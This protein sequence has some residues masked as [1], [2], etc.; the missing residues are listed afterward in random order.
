MPKRLP[1]DFYEIQSKQWKKSILIL[2][3]LVLFYFAAIGLITLAAL[4]SV[5]LFV[6]NIL[7]WS[8]A[9]FWKWL[10]AVLAVASIVAFLHF[11]EAR[12]TGAPYI[13]KRLD[14]RPP[15]PSDHYH[16]QFADTVEEMR[17]ASGLPRVK[18]YIIPQFAVNSMALIEPDGTPCVVV[19]EGLL[20]DCTRNELQAMAAHELA[21]ISRGDAF[22][23][24]LVCSLGNFLEKL[25]EAL[26]PDDAPAQERAESGRGGAPP[27]FIYL[28]LISTSIIVRLLSALLSRERET[29]ADAAA[30]EISRDP[31]A[32]ARLLYKAH[33]K[34][35]LIGDF[36]LTYSPLFIVAPQLTGESEGFFSRLFNSHPPLMKRI[37]LLAEQAGLEPA[38]VIQ[39]VWKDQ[40][41][42][43]EARTRLHSFAE[44]GPE[45][46]KTE[47]AEM[48]TP[49]EEKKTWLIQD[50]KGKWQGPF[51]LEEILFLPYFTSIRIVRNLTE[52]V[53][54][55]AREFP[56]IRL[57]LQRLGKKKP[58]DPSKKDRCPRCGVPLSEDF[59]EGVAIKTC[60]RCGGK[61]VDSAKMERILLRREFDFSEA[62]VEKARAFREQ[63]LLN[64]LKKQKEKEKEACRFACPN[65]GYRMLP[66]PYNYQYFIPVDKCLACGQIW[67]DADELEIL[68]V[69]IEKKA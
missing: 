51:A 18:A 14:A 67:F 24:T 60:L 34:S 19:T 59:Y 13:L 12:R 10:V 46:S 43:E 69:L 7:V 2:A 5:G 37:K 30:V 52:D 44:Y 36:G 48:A 31:M 22:Y 61:L 53:T 21:H 29:L 15:D 6:A 65:C 54:A 17:I 8:P 58:I 11:Y 49:S 1:R 50:S 33:L 55:Q 62:L 20:A 39:Q 63:F 35:S 27:V 68:Q 16:Q 42:R 4:A 25:R 3:V 28:T 23:V 64:P 47:D 41:L 66:R 26:E 57:A 56:Q 45:T 9:F 38:H 40:K 32:L